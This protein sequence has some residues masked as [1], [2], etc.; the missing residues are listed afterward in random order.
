MNPN[1][2]NYAHCANCDREYFDDDMLAVAY[3]GVYGDGSEYGTCP[4]CGKMMLLVPQDEE[5]SDE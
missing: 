1:E 3:V 4:D 2:Y 5:Q